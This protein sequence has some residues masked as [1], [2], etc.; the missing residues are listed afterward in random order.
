MK[1]MVSQLIFK[2]DLSL[3]TLIQWGRNSIFRLSK[4]IPKPYNTKQ[5]IFRRREKAK[6]YRAKLN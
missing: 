2:L 1:N 5:T 3:I 6:F 4:I